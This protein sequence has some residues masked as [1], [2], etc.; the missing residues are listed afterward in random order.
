MGL[1][2]S[3]RISANLAVRGTAAVARVAPL[4][5][6][7]EI[8]PAREADAERRVSVRVEV[9]A[10]PAPASTI[11]QSAPR[12][13]PSASETS[14]EPEI[15]QLIAANTAATLAR[16]RGRDAYAKSREL[17]DD[18]VLARGVCVRVDA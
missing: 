11:A 8:V 6:V 14:L 12:S 13:L 9:V 18:V 5:A 1:D 3:G 16:G 2:E 15:A 10:A 7:A 4:E 17:L